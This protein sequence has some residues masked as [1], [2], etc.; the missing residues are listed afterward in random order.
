MPDNKD[1]KGAADRARVAAEQQYEV[2]YFAK[3]HGI[4]PDEARR[5]IHL[6]GPSRAKA[7]AAATRH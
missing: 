1:K 2:S 7:D 5:I 4:T 3:K 6:A